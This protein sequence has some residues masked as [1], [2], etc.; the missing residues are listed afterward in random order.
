M[1]LVTYRD[2]IGL[3]DGLQDRGLYPDGQVELL[4]NLRIPLGYVE[5][6]PLSEGFLGDR[7]DHV[8]QIVSGKSHELL[9]NGEV[10]IDFL[11]V[12]LGPLQHGQHRH[13]LVLRNVNLHE[14]LLLEYLIL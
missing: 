7:M 5:G 2:V 8:A 1:K 10:L 4:G 14:V 9:L 11:A 13:G 12:R 6:D 3:L